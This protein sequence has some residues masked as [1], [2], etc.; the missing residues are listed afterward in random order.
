M[1]T[2]TCK[3]KTRNRQPRQFKYCPPLPDPLKQA[4]VANGTL[5]I[6]LRQFRRDLSS[7]AKL[8]AVNRLLD[9]TD[10]FGRALQWLRGAPV[11]TKDGLDELEPISI[12]SGSVPDVAE[13]TQ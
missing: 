8:S 7:P 4:A 10:A 9:A 12:E 6:S 1:D 13:V 5:K 11:A 2:F 3:S